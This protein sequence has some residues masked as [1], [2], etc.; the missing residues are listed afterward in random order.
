MSEMTSRERVIKTL[1][2]RQPDRVP[3]DLGST[4]VT[5]ITKNAYINLADALRENPGEIELSDTI[6]QLPVV[7]EDILKRLEVDIRGL[8]PNF[9]RKNPDLEDK[10]DCFWFTDEWGVKWKMPK[11]SL[12]FSMAGC[13]F[14]G[15]ISEQDI[16]NFPWPDPAEPALLEG[17]QQKA[18]EYYRQGYAVILE[19]LCAGI[20]EMSC[21]VRGTE[22]FCMDLAMNP[23]I[24]SKLLDKFVE[25][26]IRFYKAA[27]EK[28][29]NYVQLIREGDDMAGQEA[30]LISPQMYREFLKPRHKQL[31]EAQRKFFSSPFYIFFHSDGAIYDIIPD[32]IEIGIDVLNPVQLTAKGMNAEKLKKEYGKDLALWGGGVDTQHVLPTAKPEQVRRN[33]ED[34]IRCFAPGGGFIFGTVHNIQD[35]VPAENIMAMIE[36]FRKLREY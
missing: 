5:G 34:R 28:L 25:L 6:Q 8:I 27:A 31:F 16:D 15:N 21:R 4:L 14:S 12:Y 20:F 23:R 17:L 13:P 9:T 3:F 19:N 33:V 2:H 29:G 32:F 11:G 22:Q 24:A 10:G 7:S 26:K 35:D 36:A 1:E 30:L 18:Q